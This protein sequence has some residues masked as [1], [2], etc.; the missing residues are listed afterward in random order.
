MPVVPSGPQRCKYCSKEINAALLTGHEETCRTA[1]RKSMGARNTYGAAPAAA[2]AVPPPSRHPHGA[3]HGD[4]STASSSAASSPAAASS[5]PPG[6]VGPNF[7]NAVEEEGEPCVVCMDAEKSHAIVPCGHLAL[8]ERCAATV[9][10]CPMCRGPKRAV[11]RIAK[12]DKLSRCRSCKHIIHP[13][14]FDSH[15]E[16]CALRMRQR[17]QDEQSAA[18]AAEQTAAAAKVTASPA[19]TEAGDPAL[20]LV[21]QPT[22]SVLVSEHHCLECRNKPVAVAFVPC[23]HKLMCMDCGKKT[24]LCPSCLR[25]VTD[26]LVTFE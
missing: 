2:A 26:V 24:S 18:A 21:R 23:G 11:L 19:P 4:P 8:C 5:S 22:S 14:V 10:D 15:Q 20:H 16:V 1:Y 13:T 25:P 3:S 7:G 9:V 6:G 12:T 17:R